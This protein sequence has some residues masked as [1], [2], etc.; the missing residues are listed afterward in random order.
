[1]CTY[2]T[3]RLAVAGSAKGAHGW[4][5]VTDASVYLDHPVHAQA[6][7]TL[8]VDLRNPAQGASARVAVELEPGAA[9]ALAEAILHA[10]DAAPS[11]LSG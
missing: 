8:N 3:E 7:H 2:R 10:L 6:E 5:A 1:M 4:F 9:R 11:D